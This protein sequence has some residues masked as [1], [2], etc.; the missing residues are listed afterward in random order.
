VQRNRIVGLQQHTA[1]AH[2]LARSLD[3]ANRTVRGNAQ[4]YWKL[5]TEAV[6]PAF[7]LIAYR[8]KACCGSCDFAQ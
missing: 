4:E 5:Q 7:L 6:V 1:G 2:V 3:F 8:L